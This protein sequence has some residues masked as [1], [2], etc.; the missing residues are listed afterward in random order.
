MNMRE[1]NY[2]FLGILIS[3]L[4]SIAIEIWSEYLIRFFDML[5]TDK[6]QATLITFIGGTVVIV[7]FLYILYRLAKKQY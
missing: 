6:N 2:F 3:T 1:Q 7:V 4:V 5:N